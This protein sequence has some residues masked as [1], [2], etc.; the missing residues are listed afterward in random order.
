MTVQL[1]QVGRGEENLSAE[2]SDAQ[3]PNHDAIAS[4]CE[5]NNETKNCSR[6][7]DAKKFVIVNSLDNHPPEHLSC[8]L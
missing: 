3:S 5:A 8:S 1:I 6:G 2:L 7:N 4:V